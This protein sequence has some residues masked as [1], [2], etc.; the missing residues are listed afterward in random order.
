VKKLLSLIF[1]SISLQA[2]AFCDSS[3]FIPEKFNWELMTDSTRFKPTFF[4]SE[5]D[6]Y[7]FTIYNKWGEAVFIT[8]IP[9]QGWNGLWNNKRGNCEA[10]TFMWTLRCEWTGDSVSVSCTDYIVC[11]NTRAVNVTALD[12][13]QCRPTVYIPNVLTPNGDGMNEWFMPTFGCPPLNYTMWIYDRWGNVIFETKDRNV[14]WDGT[15]KGQPQQSDV[16]VCKITWKAY[17]GDKQRT[18][19]SQ[20]TL[21]R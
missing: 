21:I 12:T 4:G 18:H 2:F 15:S 11:M 20:V 16:Y 3:I 1:I 5:P 8:N 9:S 17:E 10:G 14:G 13:L 6:K 7:E 19:I